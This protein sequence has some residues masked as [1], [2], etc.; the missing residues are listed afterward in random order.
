[1][2]LRVAD[3]GG[4]AS[5][6]ENRFAGHR[7]RKRSELPAPVAFQTRGTEGVGG[8]LRRV[9]CHEARLERGRDRLDDPSRPKLRTRGFPDRLGD[10]R[11]IPLDAFAATVDLIE[12]RFEARFKHGV[13]P[14]NIPEITLKVPGDDRKS[15]SSTAHEMAILKVLKES[16]LVSSA[17][18]AVRMIEQGG[19]RMNGEKVTDKGLAVKRGDTV[20][21]QVGKR[22]F[23]RVTLA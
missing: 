11:G 7:R 5:A 23:A 21:L 10:R 15:A 1:M 6:L 18:E 19:V 3:L 4:E 17:S 9:P 16:Q 20:V 2:T 13:V 22:K 8:F 14:E 12:Q